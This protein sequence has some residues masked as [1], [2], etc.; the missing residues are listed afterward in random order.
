MQIIQ[1]GFAADHLEMR[2]HEMLLIRSN[3]NEKWHVRYYHGSATRGFNCRRWVK[4]VSDNRLRKDDVCVFELIKKG[5]RRKAMVVH[6]VRKVGG[7][8]VLLG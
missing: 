8:F 7:R 6:V 1:N 4:F 5:A 3:R 2:S